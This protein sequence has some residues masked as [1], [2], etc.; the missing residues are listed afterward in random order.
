M[1]EKYP[2]TP[3]AVSDLLE[4][5]DRIN[6]DNPEAADP[7]EDAILRA[8]DLLASSPSA[9]RL[10]RRLLFVSRRRCRF[11]LGMRRALMHRLRRPLTLCRRLM[12]SGRR[13]RPALRMRRRRTRRGRSPRFRRP[14]ARMLR[15]C[16]PGRFGF[17]SRGAGTR[18]GSRSRFRRSHA[19]MLSRYGSGRLGFSLGRACMR[20]GGG[21]GFRASRIRMCRR[22]G[23]G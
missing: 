6:Q 5:C 17:S 10:P 11:V 15:R 19:C 8:C 7:V 12:V 1:M 21:P 3:E 18:R 4:I 16:G 2:L 20:R 22:R 13:G 14:R 9:N 23:L